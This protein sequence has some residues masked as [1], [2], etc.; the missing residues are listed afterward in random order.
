[1]IDVADETPFLAP[2]NLKPDLPIAH[3]LPQDFIRKWLKDLLPGTVPHLFPVSGN[4]QLFH[5]GT[6]ISTS[7]ATARSCYP[8]N[9]HLSQSFLRSSQLL[10]IYLSNFGPEIGY[11]N[12]MGR[13]AKDTILFLHDGERVHVDT[14]VLDSARN[15][16]SK[17]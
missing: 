13:V 10:P 6:A 3:K 14:Q 5:G 8:Q 9:L 4:H 15:I 12:S 16:V 2:N 17:L 1:M 11:H 7:F